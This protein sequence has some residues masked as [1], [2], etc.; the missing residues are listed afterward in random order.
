MYM[1][2][3]TYLSVF[4]SFLLLALILGF[5]LAAG[6]ESR[7]QQGGGYSGPFLITNPVPDELIQNATITARYKVCSPC[8]N[9]AVSHV[10]LQLDGGEVIHDV[11]FDGVYQFTNVPTGS[12]MLM[13]Y[14]ADA[15]HAQVGDAFSVRFNS[16]VPNGTPIPQGQLNC[17]LLSADSQIPTGFGSPTDYYSQVRD[18]LMKV[19]CASNSVTVDVGNSNNTNYQYIYHQGY[20]SKGG[21][22]WEPVEFTSAQPQVSNAW[23]PQ[24]AS[25]TISITSQE[26][27]QTNSVLS[28]TCTWISNSQLSSGGQWKCGCRDQQCA[29][30][31][32]QIQQFKQ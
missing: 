21:S 11:D 13:G 32:W 2:H 3:K 26:L 4:A 29:Q 19:T 17:G 16:I 25:V 1:P 12:H 30:N 18:L 24:S 31:Y 20:L 7:A 14:Y 28:Y 27:S 23:F 9:G 6:R 8:S 5:G 22:P 15:N 10:H